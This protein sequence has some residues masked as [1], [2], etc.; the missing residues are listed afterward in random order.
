M[1]LIHKHSFF[2]GTL[3]TH[4][5]AEDESVSMEILFI[6]ISIHVGVLNCYFHSHPCFI[7]T[8]FI[9]FIQHTWSVYVYARI[10]AY[11]LQCISCRMS[12]AATLRCEWVC[13]CLFVCI[14]CSEKQL[15]TY[16]YAWMCVWDRERE[17]DLWCCTYSIFIM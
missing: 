11:I 1:L 8:H 2:Y 4:R 13:M 15:C 9:C 16:N 6:N 12:E 17:Y 3:E 10:D 14:L 5:H 7:H